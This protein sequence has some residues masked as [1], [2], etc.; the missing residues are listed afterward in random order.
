[1]RFLIKVTM[2]VEAGNAFVRDPNF[3][4]RMEGLLG[5]I[6]PEAAYFAVEGGQRA[7]YLIVQMAEVS[8]L[9]S[10]AEPFWLSLNA[11]VEFIPLMDRADMAKATPSIIQ[12]A[13]KYP[14]GDGAPARAGRSTGRAP[15]T[16]GRSTSRSWS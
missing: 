16:A 2:P 7:M 10:V 12:A 9:P 3:S 4:K 15:E 14:G 13:K 6:K 8:Q 1:M 5:D 11:S